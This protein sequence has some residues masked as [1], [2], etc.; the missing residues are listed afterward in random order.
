MYVAPPGLL[1]RSVLFCTGLLLIDNL[2]SACKKCSFPGLFTYTVILELPVKIYI[3][4]IKP[5]IRVP[6]KASNYYLTRPVCGIFS[7]DV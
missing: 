2:L 5:F 7:T 3:A 6:G 1:L 4:D